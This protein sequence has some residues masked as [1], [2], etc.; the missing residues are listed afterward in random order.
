M[1]QLVT[2][3][4]NTAVIENEENQLE[5][6]VPDIR[7]GEWSDIGGRKYMED[8]HVCITDLAK[9]FGYQFLD[10]EAI[11]FFGVSI[12]LTLFKE[13]LLHSVIHM[14]PYFGLSSKVIQNGSFKL[15]F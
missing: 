10:G 12:S 9:N 4:E 13:F 3:C 2:I 8:T 14:A 11:S 15:S 1:L 5:T 7:S 6:F